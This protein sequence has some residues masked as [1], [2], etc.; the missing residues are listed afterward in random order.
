MGDIAVIPDQHDLIPLRVIDMDD[1]NME[2]HL[3]YVR[4]DE[5]ACVRPA[6]HCLNRQ[7]ANQQHFIPKWKKYTGVLTRQGMMLPCSDP[8]EHVM[9]RLTGR[10][11]DEFKKR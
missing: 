1:P 2:E 11:V 3:A 7:D 9:H 6:K 4:V 10:P 5:I 8:I